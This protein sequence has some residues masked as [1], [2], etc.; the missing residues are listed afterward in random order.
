MPL[1]K[2]S[3]GKEYL[4]ALRE[5]AVPFL[6]ECQPQLLL[7]CAGF[8]ALQADPLATMTLIPM[9]YAESVRMIVEENGFPAERIAVGLE[10]GYDLSMDVGMPAGLAQTCAA[11]IGK[12]SREM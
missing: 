7:I 3:G 5:K 10:G 6:L 11:L 9:D 2:G 12:R 4:G 1:Q 8:D